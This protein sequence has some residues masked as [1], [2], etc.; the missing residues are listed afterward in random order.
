MKQRESTVTYQIIKDGNTIVAVKYTLEDAVEA[1]KKL[2]NTCS[3]LFFIRTV[4]TEI[5]D[6]ACYQLG[7]IKY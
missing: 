2:S 4:R 6:L 1:A 7:K 3:S 5:N